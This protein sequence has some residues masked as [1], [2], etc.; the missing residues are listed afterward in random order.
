MASKTSLLEAVRAFDWK[1]VDADLRERPDLLG[2]REERAKNWLH[3]LCSTR[4]KGRKPAA[5]IKTADVLLAHGIDVHAHAFTEGSWKAT[6]VW[7]CVSW[8]RNLALAE[9]LLKLGATADYSMF[10]ACWNDD[11]AALDLLLKYGA[12]VDDS[13]SGRETPFLGAIT[14]S[15]FR[16][17]E[18]LLQRGADVNARAEDG[19]TPLI[20]AAQRGLVAVGEMLIARGADM[21]LRNKK[22][23]NAW[24]IAAMANHLEFVELLRKT[25]EKK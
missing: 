9:H 5:S 6:P 12:R 10:A 1:A 8:G 18:T 3:V 17:A 4:L 24:L 14:W 16:F 21:E 2:H 20:A 23:Q 22:E 15:R 19:T 11:V 7:W 25:R 13:T